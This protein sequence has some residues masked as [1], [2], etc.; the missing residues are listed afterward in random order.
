MSTYTERVRTLLTERRE[1]VRRLRRD[2]HRIASRPPVV[3]SFIFDE[4]G[5]MIL[6]AQV[7]FPDAS[8]RAD[9]TDSSTTTDTPNDY[10]ACSCRRKPRPLSE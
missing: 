7:R 1:L 9:T 10:E 8:G 4:D 5:R 2:Q 3:F 6:T